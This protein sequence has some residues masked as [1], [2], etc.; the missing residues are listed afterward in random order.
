MHHFII[1]STQ[2]NG[3]IDA[4]ESHLRPIMGFWPHI[5]DSKMK[6]LLEEFNK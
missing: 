6:E 4:E 5:T 2:T 3:L 1:I